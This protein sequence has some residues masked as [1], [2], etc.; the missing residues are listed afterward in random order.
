MHFLCIYFWCFSQ[1]YLFLTVITT[2]VFPS[3]SRIQ[4]YL[5]NKNSRGFCLCFIPSPVG[6]AMISLGWNQAWLSATVD[7]V[8]SVTLAFLGTMADRRNLRNSCCRNG[9]ISVRN[10]LCRRETGRALK[11]E[12]LQEGMRE[13]L[14]KPS[15]LKVIV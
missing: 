8:L 15:R 3:L 14:Y 11:Q 12:T 13:W 1:F 10:I 7:S 5:P 2:A 4:I 9:R 6:K